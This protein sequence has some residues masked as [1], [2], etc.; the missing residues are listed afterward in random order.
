[1]AGRTLL[2]RISPPDVL[3][4]IFG[5]H[6]GVTL[7]M[8]AVGAVIVPPLVS[9]G[10]AGLAFALTAAILPLV[11]LLLLF[12]LLAIDREA[13]VP[14]VEITLLRSMP[15]FEHLRPP[16][17]ESLARGLEPQESAPGAVI[18][19]QGD[20]GDAYYVIADGEVEVAVDGGRVARHGRGAGFGEIALLRDAPRNATVTALTLCHLYRLERDAFLTAVTRHAPAAGAAEEIAQKRSGEPTVA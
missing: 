14:I 6:E 1:M 4:R 12:R 3:A 10:G 18:I 15:I 20:H 13:L 7:A 9:A 2:Q 8:F 17:L 5:I 11:V 19:R 16:V